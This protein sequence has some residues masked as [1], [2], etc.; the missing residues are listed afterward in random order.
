MHVEVS[1]IRLGYEIDGQGPALVLLHAFPLNR[2]MWRPQVAALRDRFTI[3]T[4]D[5]RGFGESDIPSGA[6]TMDD[7]AQDVLRLLDALGQ[8]RVM[9]GGCSIGG[10]VAFRVLARAADRISAVLIA[11]SR[12][13][14][15][16]EEGRQRRHAAIKRIEAD[17]PSVFLEEFASLLVGP[18]TKAQ[19]P[20]VIAAVRQIIGSPDPR[21]LIAALS[22]LATR[23][24]SRPLLPSITAPTLVVVGEED[25]VTPPASSEEM[26]GALPHARMITIPGAGH[27]ANLEAPEAFNRATREFLL[28]Q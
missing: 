12:A 6:L 9:L 13:E 17:G 20:G 18:T 8:T 26:V 7:Y 27:L 11:D 22:A 4:P 10:Y 1:G 14:P 2:A 16:T 19:R 3:I 15:D 28:A 25:T 24:D 23:P 5:F 21:S